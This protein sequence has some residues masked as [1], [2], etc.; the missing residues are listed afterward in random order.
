[1][2]RVFQFLA[3]AIFP[4][5][6]TKFVE[7]LFLYSLFEAEQQSELNLMQYIKQQKLKRLSSRHICHFA[8]V[9]FDLRISSSTSCQQLKL[10]PENMEELQTRLL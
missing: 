8:Y 6:N 5:T 2:S 3:D 1:M 9:L 4:A 10:P 7:L